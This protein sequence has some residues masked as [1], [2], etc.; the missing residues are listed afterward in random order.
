[1][2]KAFRH[3]D[4]W[5]DTID[6]FTLPF[7]SFRPTEILGYPA[8]GNDVFH[9]QGIHEGRAITAY[10]KV[11]RQKGAD[12]KN[13]T[14]LMPQIPHPAV[15]RILDAG[16]GAPPFSVTEERPGLRLSVI[17][18]SNEDRA[19]LSYMEEYG[20]TLAWIHSLRPAA[21]PVADRRFFH[22]PAEDVL[23]ALGLSWMKEYF[24]CPPQDS[25]TVFCHGDFHYANILWQRHHISGILDFELAG[26]G[27]R[28][29]DI[30]WALI[31][32]PGQRFMNTPE[33]EALFL[34]GYARQGQYDPRA[35]TYYMAQIYIYFLK[36]SL[37]DEEYSTYV[38]AWLQNHCR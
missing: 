25:S 29:F 4:K 1:M 20:E 17:L 27:K 14:A 28:D 35:V 23:A 18:G 36:S 19:S 34:A 13:E 2:D 5:R 33:E 32:R 7:H 15:P 9:L 3:P 37:E 26:Y 24:A 38:R 12:I 31:R 16:F 11:A 30:A 8:A 6:P 10:L 22:A 21:S